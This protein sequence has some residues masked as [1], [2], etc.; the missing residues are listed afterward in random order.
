MD[1]C[2]FFTFLERSA[3]SLPSLPASYLTPGPARVAQLRGS[4]FQPCSREKGS[5][6]AC[7]LFC[8]TSRDER[9]HIGCQRSEGAQTSHPPH[10]VVRAVAA[11]A[12]S[13]PHA[14]PC[15]PEEGRQ[16][17]FTSP[18]PASQGK[19]QA[20]NSGVVPKCRW[21]YSP[22][23]SSWCWRPPLGAL[24]CFAPSLFLL[25]WG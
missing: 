19:V 18:S 13:G 6:P 3:S 25:P 16:G 23:V 8:P 20:K 9:E 5:L 21:P 2:G 12:Q 11:P 24:R 4:A 1:F 17:A 10:C 15:F 22:W 14:H 7:C